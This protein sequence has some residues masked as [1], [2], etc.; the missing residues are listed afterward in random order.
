MTRALLGSVK[1]EHADL[2]CLICPTCYGQFDYWQARIG[3][4]YGEEFS[5]P[6]V[7][8]LQLLAFAQ[9]VPYD[10]LGF[11]KQRLKPESLRRFE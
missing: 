1:E 8:C 9:G 3:K 6:P 2:L 7:Y 5:S 11:E 10:R 4:Q